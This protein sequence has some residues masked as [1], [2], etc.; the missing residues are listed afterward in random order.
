M[1]VVFEFFAI[2]KA[3][4]AG[5]S[6]EIKECLFNQLFE[7]GALYM[8]NREKVDKN[9]IIT[10]GTVYDGDTVVMQLYPDINFEFGLDED[11]NIA[12]GQLLNF[13]TGE[14]LGE[15]TVMKKDNCK[16]IDKWGFDE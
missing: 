15:Y 1:K 13:A 6:I 2:D 4:P 10:S 14:T 9:L 12:V 11:S 3:A 7:L 8:H 16:V 5:I